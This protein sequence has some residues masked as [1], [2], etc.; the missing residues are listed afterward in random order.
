MTSTPSVLK[1][2][3]LTD[4]R[5]TPCRASVFTLATISMQSIIM[6]SSSRLTRPYS[7]ASRVSQLRA[8]SLYKAQRLLLRSVTAFLDGCKVTSTKRVAQ[9]STRSHTWR[10]VQKALEVKVVLA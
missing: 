3:V 8:K 5:G 7:W 10:R 2:Q 6:L 1:S 4:R 9:E